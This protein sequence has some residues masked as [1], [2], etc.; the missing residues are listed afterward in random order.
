[1]G[2]GICA[3]W[4]CRREPEEAPLADLLSV[5]ELGAVAAEVT[6]VIAPFLRCNLS[7]QP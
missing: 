5:F 1:V 2:S 7:P 3:L 6:T 4:R